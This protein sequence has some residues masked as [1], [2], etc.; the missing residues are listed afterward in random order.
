MP[1]HTPVITPSDL[2]K[3]KTTLNQEYHALQNS[4]EN[5]TEKES[6]KKDEKQGK[7]DS[8]TKQSIEEEF[9]DAIDDTNVGTNLIENEGSMK[10]AQKLSIQTL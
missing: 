3:K 8:I 10:L 4:S 1:V 7:T 2:I 9:H 6:Q 5:I